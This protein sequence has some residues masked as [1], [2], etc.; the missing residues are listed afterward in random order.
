[1]QYFAQIK[2]TVVTDVIVI[3]DSDCDNLEYPASEPIG[4]AYIASLG[5]EEEWLQT[6]IDGLYRGIYAGIGYT[7]DETLDEFVLPPAPP[8]PPEPV[9]PTVKK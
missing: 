1:M 8:L 5:Y 9:A 2:E 7:Y 6:S 4:Q 3:S